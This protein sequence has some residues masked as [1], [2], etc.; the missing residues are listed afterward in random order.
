MGSLRAR[1]ETPL[2]VAWRYRS[3]AALISVPVRPARAVSRKRV[4]H[5]LGLRRCF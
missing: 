4:P 5:S 3:V 1:K 2:D